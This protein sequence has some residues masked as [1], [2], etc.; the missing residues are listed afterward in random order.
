MI[1]RAEAV[2]LLQPAAVWQVQFGG[3]YARSPH[4][5]AMGAPEQFALLPQSEPADGC[6][7]G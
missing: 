2:I 7:L 5:V 4:T 1:H 6:K 3:N